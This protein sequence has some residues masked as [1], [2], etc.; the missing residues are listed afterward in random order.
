MNAACTDQD[1]AAERAAQELA[2]RLRAIV[3]ESFL[4]DPLAFARTYWVDARA[5]HWRCLPPQPGAVEQ[6]RMAHRSPPTPDYLAAKA[7][8]ET[9]K[10]DA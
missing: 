1:A 6:A 7:A 9:R 4:A 10:D 8:L 2:R 5:E 3:P